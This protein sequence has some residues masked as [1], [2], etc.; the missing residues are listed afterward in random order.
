MAAP[1]QTVP[2]EMR[3]QAVIIVDANG[4]ERAR[5]GLLPHD[6]KLPAGLAISDEAGTPRLAVLA[7]NTT[8][9]GVSVN[10]ADGKERIGI[11]TDGESSGIGLNAGDG[12]ERFNIGVTRDGKNAG[13]ELTGGKG[14]ISI[15]MGVGP[16]GGGLSLKDG[17]GKVRAGIGLPSNAGPGFTANDEDGKEIWR[18]P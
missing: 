1:E 8:G 5:L 11:G 16:E 4:K 18:A 7:S 2:M 9:A 12:T 10:G 6:G 13:L 14:K 3:T 17:S 15:G